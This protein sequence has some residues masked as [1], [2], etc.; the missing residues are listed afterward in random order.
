MGSLS[1]AQAWTEFWNYQGEAS[2]CCDNAPEILAPV[3]AH[4]RHFG[5]ALG[6][7][8]RVLDVACGSGA[9]GQALLDAD[10]SLRVIG[11]DF[12]LLPAHRDPRIEILSGTRMERLPFADRSFDAAI[13]QFGFEYGCIEDAARELGRVLMPGAPISLLVH[14][15]EAPIATDSLVHRSA[16]QAICG[17]EVEMAFLSG[18]AELLDRQLA[19]IRKECPHQR[20]VDEAAHGLRRLIGEAP[21][22]RVEIWQAIQAALAPELVMLR[23]LERAAVAPGTMPVWLKPLEAQFELD[24]PDVML[25]TGGRPLCWKVQGVRKSALH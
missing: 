21:A 23:E 17:R 12:A 24:R 18:S 10:D 1:H 20:I 14:H 7:N 2:G 9:A 5:R 15:S 25:M 11:V 4:W 22:Q 3:K 19:R 16:L 8:S 13:S 6:S